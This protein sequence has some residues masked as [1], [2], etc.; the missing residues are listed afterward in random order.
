[1]NSVHGCFSDDE[2]LRRIGVRQRGILDGFGGN[3]IRNAETEPMEWA[4]LA[5]LPWEPAL[6]FPHRPAEIS[7]TDGSTITLPSGVS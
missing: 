2:G 5:E 4:L 1:M 6:F 3:N 7:T